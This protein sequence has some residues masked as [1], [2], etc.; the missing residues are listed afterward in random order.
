MDHAA[1]EVL[2][3]YKNADGDTLRIDTIRMSGTF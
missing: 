2:R 3:L 1:F